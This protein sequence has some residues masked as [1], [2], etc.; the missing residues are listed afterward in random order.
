MLAE[1][2]HQ[3][4]PAI[5]PQPQPSTTTPQQ[6]LAVFLETPHCGASGSL[7]VWLGK[8]QHDCSVQ[9]RSALATSGINQNLLPSSTTHFHGSHLALK[10]RKRESLHR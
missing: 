6:F 8:R 1:P 7:P 9:H 4:L 10:A 3:Q 2:A 5:P